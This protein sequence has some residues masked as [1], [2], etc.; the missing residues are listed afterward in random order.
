MF[1]YVT[2]VKP[3][4]RI[5]DFDV[6]K[7]AYCG[8]CF[9]LQHN[10][11]L[12]SKTFLNYDF[13]FVSLIGRSVAGVTPAFSKKRCNTNCLKKCNV[14]CSHEID[15]YSAAALI[16]S[17]YFKLIDDVSDE[18]LLKRIAARLALPAAKA[19]YRR[20]QKLYPDMAGTISDCFKKQA[21]EENNF[22][23]LDGAAHNTSLA[24]S[25]IFEGL[26]GVP[27]T[28]RVLSRFGYLIGR[29]VYIA[30]AA[31]DLASDV[32]NGRF[33]PLASIY[34]SEPGNWQAKAIE[35]AKL[36]L[37]ATASEVA[38]AYNLLDIVQYREILNNII[39]LGLKR[40]IA[41]IGKT[42]GKNNDESLQ[43]SWS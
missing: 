37:N 15:R 19:G 30:D 29:F 27:A 10:F 7:A 33:N 21:N 34:D 12:L 1:G 18:K 8:I 26:S 24:L 43:H 31:D 14:Q 20:A 2:P 6:Y 22:S 38:S 42:K 32:K 17:A 40:T 23:G 25:G 11:G 28:R 41:A 9:E 5:C 16:T 36:E 35:F 39:F 4:M 3:Q 13:V